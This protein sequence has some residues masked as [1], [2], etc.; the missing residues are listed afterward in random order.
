MA[1]ASGQSA[2][3]SQAMR[4]K[5]GSGLRVRRM[6]G[7][8]RQLTPGRSDVDF[9]CNL[10]GVVY[11]DTEVANGA[12]DLGVAKKLLN[13]T[14]IAGPPIDQRGF[15]SPNRVRT[16]LQRVATDA[17]NPFTDETRV[18]PRR[19]LAVGPTPTGRTGIDHAGALFPAGIQ[20]SLGGF[21]PS[22]SN[23]TGRPVFFCR[24]V[25]RS[26]V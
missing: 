15:G 26:E 20:Q 8:A 18:R 5:S 14:Q 3:L 11:F 2:S 7:R 22:F 1:A 17:R 19:K 21:A 23:R 10:Y 24:T 13:G 9:L 4:R 6:S 12:L 25:A 16:E